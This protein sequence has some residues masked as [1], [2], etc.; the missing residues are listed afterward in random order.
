MPNRSNVN[1]LV[2]S[3]KSVVRSKAHPLTTGYRLSTTGW[4][5]YAATL[6]PFQRKVYAAVRRIPRGQA[7][8]YQ[9]VARAI[10]QPRATRAVGQAL[11]CNTRPDLVP[12][13]RVISANGSLGGY[14]WGAAAKHRRLAAERVSNAPGTGSLTANAP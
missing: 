2:R 6:T 9:W 3:P 8:S 10:G 1:S 4:R 14:A 12:C 5:R 11:N 13:H 7:R